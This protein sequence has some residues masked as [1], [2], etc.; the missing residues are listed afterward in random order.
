MDSDAA[1]FGNQ[2]AAAP[3]QSSAG[4]YMNSEMAFNSSE[5]RKMQTFGTLLGGA[6]GERQE[7]NLSII[8]N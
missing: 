1:N 7:M 8:E 5:L 4:H 2:S 3:S 6:Q